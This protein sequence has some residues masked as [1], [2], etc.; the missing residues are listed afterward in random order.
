MNFIKT[1]T[2]GVLLMSIAHLAWADIQAGDKVVGVNLGS[3]IPL[4]TNKFENIAKTGLAVGGHLIYFVTSKIGLGVHL[5][6]FSFGEKSIDVSSSGGVISTFQ[7]DVLSLQ[8]IGRWSVLDRDRVTSYLFAGI[9]VNDFTFT[10]RVLDIK[11]TV[12][13]TDLA[14]EF[15]RRDR[16]KVD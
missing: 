14:S 3:V 2:L 8:A 6:Y 5:D 7:V 4:S 12:S 1:L 16:E 15:W 10:E 13:E 11:A 9:G